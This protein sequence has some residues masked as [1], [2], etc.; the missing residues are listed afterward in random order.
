MKLIDY[1]KNAIAFIFESDILIA[2]VLVGLIILSM[3]YAAKIS[4]E[5]QNQ[6]AACER[7][8]K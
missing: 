8:E 2:V 5:N 1:L 3:S 4:I 6:K 7:R